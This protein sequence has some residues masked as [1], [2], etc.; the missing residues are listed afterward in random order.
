MTLTTHALVGAAAASLTP[1]YPLAGFC[2]GFVSHFAID[3]IPHWDYE[4]ASLKLNREDK[5][6]TFIEPGRQFWAD[7]STVAGDA[8]FGFAASIFIFSLALLHA[9]LMAVFVG[10]FGALVPD[11]LH[12]MYFKWHL[13]WLVPLERFHNWVGWWEWKGKDRWPLG[14]ALQAALVLAVVAALKFLVY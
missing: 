6:K 8:L 1:Q 12:F 2:L 14:V 10:A 11:G 4:L 13:A 9:P 5:L 3:A 7:V